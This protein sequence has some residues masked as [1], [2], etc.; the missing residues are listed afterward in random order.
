MESLVLDSLFNKTKN[1]HHSLQRVAPEYDKYS[2][3]YTLSFPVLSLLL[4]WFTMG[5]FLLLLDTYESQ[6]T[7][8]MSSPVSKTKIGFYVCLPLCWHSSD[9]YHTTQPLCGKNKKSINTYLWNKQKK[10]LAGSLWPAPGKQLDWYQTLSNML[11]CMSSANLGGLIR[12]CL[13][14]VL[15]RSD[16]NDILSFWL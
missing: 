8:N 4:N 9:F 1:V 15:R 11:F 7:N 2:L 14:V 3:C 12:M 16:R 5:L 10:L 13:C 6:L